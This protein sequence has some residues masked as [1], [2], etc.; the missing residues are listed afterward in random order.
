M[1]PAATSRAGAMESVTSL[2]AELHGL[3]TRALEA[4][5]GVHDGL[6][7][8]ARTAR[9]RGLLSRATARR[10]ERV[11]VAA[12]YVR[13]ISTARVE[14]VFGELARELALTQRPEP[15]PDPW[16]AGLD[17]WAAATHTPAAAPPPK[18]ASSVAVQ[19]SPAGAARHV[20]TQAS[21]HFAAAGTQAS[22]AVAHVGVV[23]SRPKR[24]SRG[25][26]VAMV[27]LAR[28]RARVQAANA[29]QAVVR[30]RQ[31][32]QRCAEYAAEV[33][34]DRAFLDVVG[35][36]PFLAWKFVTQR[37]R[38]RR[39]GSSSTSTCSRSSAAT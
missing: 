15:E 22:P 39:P 17:P 13:H 12:A 9:R 2:M 24:S 4:R 19:T 8:A 21:P 10:M 35:K 7:T 23:V 14:L 3:C 32:R 33:C 11:D 16:F 1:Q 34:A 31:G 28:E 29:I 38:A 27:D 6:T 36:L 30:G 37:A 26:G 20:A 5:V 25:T 18:G